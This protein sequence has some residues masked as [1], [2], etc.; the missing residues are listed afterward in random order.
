MLIGGATAGIFQ[1]SSWQHS[2]VAVAHAVF[3][4]VPPGFAYITLWGQFNSI[5]P[6]V[7]PSVAACYFSLE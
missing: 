1:L 5:L 2:G 3:G 7:G 6:S 4:R